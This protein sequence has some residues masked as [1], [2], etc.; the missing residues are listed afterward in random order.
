LF[1]WF[2]SIA[3][4]DENET[5]R[6]VSLSLIGYEILYFGAALILT[7]PQRLDTFGRFQPMRSLHLLYTF[8]IILGG[9]LLGKYVLKRSVWRWALLF[10]PLCAGMWFAQMQIFSFS[11][12]I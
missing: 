5:L 1:W 9:G 3:R 2:M 4:A 8:L 11:P 6:V 7:I 10:V 12:H